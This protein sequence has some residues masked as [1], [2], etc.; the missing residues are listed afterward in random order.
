MITFTDAKKAFVKT[1]LFW[2]KPIEK[3]LHKTIPSQHNTVA[4]Q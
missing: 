4:N 3:E 1:S 2:V